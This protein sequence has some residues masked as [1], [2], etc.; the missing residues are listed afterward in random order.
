MALSLLVAPGPTEVSPEIFAARLAGEYGLTARSEL[1]GNRLH[2]WLSRDDSGA[3]ADGQEREP[4]AAIQRS[5]PEPTTSAS[6]PAQDDAAPLAG[7]TE[8]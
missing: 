6:G 7:L 2:V 1:I 4:G 8:V 5:F 3:A